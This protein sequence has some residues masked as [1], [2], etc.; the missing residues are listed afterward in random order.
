MK[1]GADLFTSIHKFR[2]LLDLFTTDDTVFVCEKV[3]EVAIC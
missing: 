3:E 2:F 1:E